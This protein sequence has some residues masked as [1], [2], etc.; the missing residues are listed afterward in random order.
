MLEKG[1]KIKSLKTLQEVNDN[2]QKLIDQKKKMEAMAHP[3][4][5]RNCKRIFNDAM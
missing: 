1:Q 3:D 4:P 5:G 2:L